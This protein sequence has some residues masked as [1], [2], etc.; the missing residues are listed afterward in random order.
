MSYLKNGLGKYDNKLEELIKLH[1]KIKHIDISLSKLYTVAIV[2]KN[3]F[4]IFDI[5]DKTGKYFFVKT[6]PTPMPIPKGIKAAFTLEFYENKAAAVV[7]DDT[8]DNL[9][10]YIFTFHEFVHCYQMK[11]EIKLKSN[12][13]VYKEA[14]ESEDYMWELN[15]PFPYEDSYFKVKTKE[16]DNYFKESKVSKIKEYFSQMKNYLKTTDF[17][18]M[19]WQEWKEG[20]ARYIENEIRTEFGVKK[21]S[22][23]ISEPFNRV[24]FYEIGS[25]YIDFILK[26]NIDLG[27]N[28]E[29]LFYEM[30]RI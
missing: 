29:E 21:N 20:F 16:L 17:E 3:N 1:E 15:Y 22:G 8:F 11:S 27:E 18:Y 7:S 4:L 24:S 28:I 23:K 25:S 5:D 10:G 19:I 30:F 6:H 14:M 13:K 9:E 12:L 2:E 26:H